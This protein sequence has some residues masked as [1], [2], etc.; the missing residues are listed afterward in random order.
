[1][2]GYIINPSWFYWLN[3]VDAIGTFF[4]AI[5]FVSIGGTIAS[6]IGYLMC[7]SEIKN[8]PDWSD[9][10][11]ARLPVWK[12]ILKICIITAAVAGVFLVFIPSKNTL[13]EM[14]IARYATYENAELTIETIK[15]AVDY[16]IEAINSL[17]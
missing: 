17:K 14:Q 2:T 4:G 5:V 16:I 15:A 13:I 11:K 3:V 10:E 8:F 9:G 12:R 1:M 7:L 6:T